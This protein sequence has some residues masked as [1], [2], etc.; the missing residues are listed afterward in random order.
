MPGLGESVAAEIDVAALFAPIALHKTIGLAVSGGPDSLALVVL[1]NRWARALPAPV[2]LIVYTLD[3]GL[4][5]QSALETAFVAG[6]AAKLGLEARVLRWAGDKPRA[7]IQAAARKARYRLIGQEMASDGAEVLV[8]AHHLND[9]AETVLMRLAHGSGLGGLAGMAAFSTVEGVTVFRPLLGTDPK[10]L[11]EVV[12]Q[13]GIVP[14]EDPSNSNRAF[15][16]VRWRQALPLLADL[17][18]DSTAMALLARRAGEADAAL[19]A[20]ADEAFDRLVAIDGFGALRIDRM[21]FEHLPRALAVKML[22]KGLAAAGGDQRPHVLGQIEALATALAAPETFRKQTL[23]GCVVHL[24]AKDLWLAR[25]PG[26]RADETTSLPPQ[27]SIVWDN[28][29]R[30]ANRSSQSPVA[31][32]MATDWNR[33]SAEALI[34]RR[35]AG[36]IE[37]LRASPLVYDGKG[38]IL[39]LGQH[40]FDDDIVVAWLSREDRPLSRMAQALD[41]KRPN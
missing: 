40:R 22:E 14:V 26:R 30:I 9:Q 13:V 39:A 20:M 2:R 12:G 37:G 18:L 6:E 23:L 8:T 36:P 32:R 3:H 5:P 4:R 10:I 34:G 35:A 38:R 11:R 17:G 27:A 25:E 16:R 21:A 24:G 31:V 29:F 33:K 7:G 41:Q 1:A 15:E 19:D 28:R